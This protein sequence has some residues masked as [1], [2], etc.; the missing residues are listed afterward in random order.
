[1]LCWVD[2]AKYLLVALT[3]PWLLVLCWRMLLPALLSFM[4]DSLL[5]WVFG[6]HRIICAAPGRVTLCECLVVAALHCPALCRL[7]GSPTLGPAELPVC[8]HR[9]DD[10]LHTVEQSGRWIKRPTAHIEKN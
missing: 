2:A 8:T 7:P 6:A 1:V 4:A 9:R 5:I 3:A 10:E